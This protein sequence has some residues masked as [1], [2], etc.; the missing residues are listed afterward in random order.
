MITLEEVK[1]IIQQ[2]ESEKGSF[3]SKTLDE[4]VYSIAFRIDFFKYAN[5]YSINKHIDIEFIFG[6]Y[7]E[8]QEEETSYQYI[9]KLCNL[10]KIK[11][12]KE[13]EIVLYQ[14]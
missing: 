5:V 9:F 10:E 13:V 8:L 4:D 1:R 12:D 6:G 3:S 11:A 2:V 14:K 7:C